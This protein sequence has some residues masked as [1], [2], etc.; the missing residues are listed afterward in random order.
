MKREVIALVYGGNEG[1]GPAKTAGPAPR[2]LL[3]RPAYAYVVEAASGLRPEAVFVSVRGVDDAA[4]AALSKSG[5]AGLKRIPLQAVPV[6]TGRG[7]P[8]VAD[9]L[10][11][12]EPAVR[13][14]LDR[15]CDILFVPAARPL[16]ETQTVR[17]LL[18]AHRACGAA[19]TFLSSAE[20]TESGPV[21]VLR[22]EDASVVLA[23]IPKGRSAVGIRRLAGLLRSSRKRLGR[24]ETE[25]SGAVPAPEQSGP[26][27]SLA[28]AELRRRKNLALARA[29]VT[30]LDPGTTW[31]DWDVAV[32]AGTVIYPFVF[33][34]GR[35]R[36]GRNC[37][38]YPHVRITNSRLG[39]GVSVLDATVIDG[40]V[41]E[42]GSQAGP[43]CRMRP[44]A[45]VRRGAK[46]GNFVE[47]KNTVFGR[48]SKAMHLSYLGDS[49]VGED[50][51][52]GAGT[53]T[54]NY[55]GVSKNRTVIGRGAFIGSGTELV[56]PVKVGR[57]AYVAAGSTITQDVAAECLAIARARQVEKPGWVAERLKKMKAGSRPS[58][59][60]KLQPRK[61]R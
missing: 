55:D 33:L 58:P 61:P 9:A 27:L 34:E 54:C 47:L 45:V 2:L 10:P 35:T 50:V 51:N 6:P 39:E 19:L 14:F 22:S 7:R 20:L 60:K 56:A 53:I 4:V 25:E 37:R 59:P 49:R 38:I 40:C 36:L 8:A 5:A 43:F 29:G 1:P 42:S 23:K 15:P 17:D 48:R 16:L 24:W 46:V 30:L 11:L 3:G 41:L 21:G 12:L 32:G 28:A 26:D 44:G 31:V 52:V 57:R 18:A 13:A